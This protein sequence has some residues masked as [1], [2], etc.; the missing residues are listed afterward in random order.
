MKSFFFILAL[1]ALF[2]VMASD[3]AAMS[4]CQKSHSF[5]TCFT[6]MNR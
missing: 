2:M 3:D 5:E 4:Q 6:Q 1:F